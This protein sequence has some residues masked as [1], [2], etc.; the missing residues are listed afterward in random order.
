MEWLIQLGAV[1]IA[2]V[3]ALLRSVRITAA[4]LSEFELHRRAEGGDAAAAHELRRR[5]LLAAIR[6]LVALKVVVAWGALALLLVA[7][8]EPWPG[9]ALLMMYGLLAELVSAG[10]WLDNLAAKAEQAIEPAAMGVVG[11]LAPLLRRFAR[12]EQPP[13]AMAIASRE[14]LADTINRD[15]TLL[16][17]SEKA[18]LQGALAYDQ[19][20]VRD[21][22]VPRDQIVCVGAGETVGPVLLDRLHKS[23]HNIYPV[24]KKDLDHLQGLL[25]MHDIMAPHPDLKTV[26]D[27]LR[28]T[29]HY[30]PADAPLSAVLG[31]SLQSGRQLF[32]VVGDNNIQGLITL[33]DALGSLLGAAPPDQ[34]YVTTDLKKVK[35]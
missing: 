1:G 32:I 28:P 30:L 21:V 17:P 18:R 2:F 27:A 9:F 7:T 13:P 34:T 19:R 8:H 6:G 24:V 16:S 5:P 22:M 10:G 12:P 4:G 14:D 3:I 20:T 29:V 26:K 11:A 33:R 31:A 15:S 25:Y 23:G 35:S